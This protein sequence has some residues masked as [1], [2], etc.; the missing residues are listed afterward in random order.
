MGKRLSE[1]YGLDIY[2][3]NAE[4]VG[5]VEDIVLNLEKGGVMKLCLKPLKGQSLQTE[6]IRQILQ[7][8]SIGYDD[9]SVI[10]EI[11]LVEK[12]PQAPTKLKG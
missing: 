7:A 10:G 1:M 8:E 11:I 2:T 5:R 12:A 6:D 4:R 3:Q 9:I